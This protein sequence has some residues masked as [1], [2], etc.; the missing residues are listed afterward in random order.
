VDDRELADHARWRL[1]EAPPIDVLGRSQVA[2]V[3]SLA[4]QAAADLRH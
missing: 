3:P 2:T 1:H 4:P